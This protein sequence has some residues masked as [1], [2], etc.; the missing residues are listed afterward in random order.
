MGKI[1]FR[2]RLRKT[3]WNRKSIQQDKTTSETLYATYPV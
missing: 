1:A 2:F 3:G